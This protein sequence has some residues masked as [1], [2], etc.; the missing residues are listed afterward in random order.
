MVPGFRLARVWKPGTQVVLYL[1]LPYAFRPWQAV[2][3]DAQPEEPPQVEV[4]RSARRRRTVTA[5]RSQDTIIVLI[6][7]R[8]SKA[9]ERAAVASL[10]R[11]V[12]QQEARRAAPRSDDGL[13][14]RAQVLA[15]SWLTSA[16]G[17][18]PVAREIR[19]VT[20]QNQR[21]GSCTPSTGVIRLSHRLQAMPSW[22][23]DY[24]L[25]HEL[26]HLVEPTHSPAFWQ[27]VNRYPE[28]DRARGYL[29]GFLA[30]QQHRDG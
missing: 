23:V 10:V 14:D 15:E 17:S 21:W 22:V 12:L 26:A 20:N 28:S 9:D 27:L 6:P 8:M 11:R 24:V 16:S 19:W 2:G 13:A 18:V 5:Y 3:V 1:L 4:R 7:Q 30:G 29:A 25:V